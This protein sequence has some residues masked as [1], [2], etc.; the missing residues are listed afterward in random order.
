MNFRSIFL[1]SNCLYF[2]GTGQ[3]SKNSYPFFLKLVGSRRPAISGQA[4][5]RNAL[6]GESPASDCGK[7]VALSESGNPA[8]FLD[9]FSVVR[10]PRCADVEDGNR[11]FGIRNA[12]GE[13]W[14]FFVIRLSRG[15]MTKKAE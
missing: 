2:A 11:G 14:S 13:R 8:A 12:V 9:T 10:M 7:R 3:P 4:T 6:A 15:R 1:R 5:R